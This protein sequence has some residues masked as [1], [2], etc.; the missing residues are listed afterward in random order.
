MDSP[1][2][3]PGKF[4]NRK[5]AIITLI[6]IA[7]IAALVLA[8]WAFESSESEPNPYKQAPVQ[9]ETDT[10]TETEDATPVDNSSEADVETDSQASAVDSADVGTIDIEPMGIVVAYKKGVPGFGYEVKRTQSGT[11]YVEFSNED[12]AGTKCTDDTGVFASILR[13]PSTDERATLER[14][15]D[16]DDEIYGLSLPEAT[17]TSDADLFGQYQASFRDGFSLLKAL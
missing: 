7:V 9:V 6:V 11:E 1:S 5:P 13:Q 4:N 8:Y 16:V 17:C 2:P 15:V 3:R 10:E 12:L 14:T